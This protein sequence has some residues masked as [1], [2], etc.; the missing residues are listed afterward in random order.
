MQNRLTQYLRLVQLV[1]GFLLVGAGLGGCQ[2]A[3]YV[4]QAA[5]GAP[6]PV[7]VPSVAAP[8]APAAVGAVS[9][10]LPGRAQRAVVL[11]RAP[12]RARAVAGARV[13]RALAAQALLGRAARHTAAAAAAAPAR[14]LRGAVL[15]APDPTPQHW[16]SK[17][18]AFLLAFF[19]GSFG[20]HRFYLGYPGHGAAF[21]GLALLT[22]LLGILAVVVLVATSA[23]TFST[24]AVLLLL[25]AALSGLA[26]EVFLIVDLVR[27]L[28]GELKPKGGEYYPRFFQSAPDAPYAPPAPDTR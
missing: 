3:S 24:A 28:T 1:A 18:V 19:L 27:I 16:R 2:R 14:Q 15:P 22:V 8:S 20:A 11:R 13:A 9:A 26:S 23:T 4:F 7:A 21:L 6:R 5:P 17:G 10:E 12:H 25:G